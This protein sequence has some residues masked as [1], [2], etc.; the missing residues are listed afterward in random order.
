ML[1]PVHDMLAMLCLSPQASYRTVIVVSSFDYSAG[2]ASNKLT[3]ADLKMLFGLDLGQPGNQ[4]R[5][6]GSVRL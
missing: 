4:A 2:A 3:L 6:F 1:R 5:P